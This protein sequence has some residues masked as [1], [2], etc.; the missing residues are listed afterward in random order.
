MENTEDSNIIREENI[1]SPTT[2]PEIPSSEKKDVEPV[3]DNNTTNNNTTTTINENEN[4]NSLENNNNVNETVELDHQP[5]TLENHNNIDETVEKPPI[6]LSE[7]V[8]ANENIQ[9]SETSPEHTT[10]IQEE[11]SE[12]TKTTTDTTTTS[13]EN[14]INRNDSYGSVDGLKHS[15]HS[16]SQESITSS[17]DLVTRKSSRTLTKEERIKRQ[18][19]ARRKKI[20]ASSQ[21]RLSR[22][23]KTYSQSSL[24]SNSGS[25]NYGTSSPTTDNTTTTTTTNTP[26]SQSMPTSTSTNPTTTTTPP[27]QQTENKPA[28]CILEHRRSIKRVDEPSK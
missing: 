23:T 12:N 9:S 19:E 17:P 18:R 21:E 7:N 3:I 2:S 4:I 15:V 1:S 6:L 28:E 16:S 24:R 5:N 27:L 8:Q 11:K 10:T 25:I 26:S 13:N 22:I 20:L 14:T